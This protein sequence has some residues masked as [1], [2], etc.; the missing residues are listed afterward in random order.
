MRN[1]YK[2]NSYYPKVPEAI[3]KNYLK[4][5][6]LCCVEFDTFHGSLS[7]EDIFQDTV[8]YVIQDVEASLLESEEDIIKHF[9]YRY[10]M[11]AFQIIQD[12]KQ[13]REIPYADYLQ[14]QKEGT[15]EQ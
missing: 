13:L 1:R 7:R 10:K 6:S 5:R 14:T 8:L 4:L 11:I 2:R 15:E 9:C 12:S 3:G